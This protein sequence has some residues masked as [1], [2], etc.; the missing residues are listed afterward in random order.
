MK[1]KRHTLVDVSDEGREFILAEL[2]GSGADSSMLRE[3]FGR[4]LLPKQAGVRVPGIVRREEGSLRSGCVPVGFCEPVS[5][6]E[7]R[8]RIVAFARREDVVRVITPYELAYLTIPRRTASMAALAEALLYAKA[9]DLVLGVWGSAAMEL[10]TGLPCTHEGSDLDLLVAAAS[11]ERLSSFMDEIKLI[12]GR[13]ALRI[14]VEL[15]LPNGYGVQL[16]ELMG[17][18]RTIMGKSIN[19]VALFPRDQVFAEL[20]IDPAPSL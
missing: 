5:R 17:Q 11:R 16:K 13:F 12:E 19:G 20:T 8:L 2:A 9:L 6:G 7:R 14:D 4:I 1:L 18:G 15:E 3:K 10:Y